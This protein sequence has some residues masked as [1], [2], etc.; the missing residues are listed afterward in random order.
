M[1]A[2]PKRVL[3]YYTRVK[4]TAPHA[5]V[6]FESQLLPFSGPERAEQRASRTTNP[7]IVI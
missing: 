6:D 3:H 2:A 7:K 4:W 1:L 5:K